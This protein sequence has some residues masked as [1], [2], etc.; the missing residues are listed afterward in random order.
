LRRRVVVPCPAGSLF[1]GKLEAENI[2]N[3]RQ[4][5]NKGQQQ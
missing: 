2:R 4:H 1:L 3:H 5:E